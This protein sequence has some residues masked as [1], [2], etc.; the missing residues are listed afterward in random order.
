VHYRTFVRMPADPALGSFK[1]STATWHAAATGWPTEYVLCCAV[2]LISAP[3]DT[4]SVLAVQ[5]E[6]L[7]PGPIMVHI[8]LYKPANGSIPSPT[9]RRGNGRRSSVEAGLTEC[10][11]AEAW[12]KTPGLQRI[13]A[14]L[15]IKPAAVG[16]AA[17][18]LRNVAG[19]GI[20]N[21]LELR[22]SPTL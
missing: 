9:C 16:L 14:M 18:S 19:R 7:P 21:K 3:G 10:A 17:L 12:L 20:T 8:N 11:H 15:V 4:T 6:C 13:A 5:V 2:L 22:G 1:C